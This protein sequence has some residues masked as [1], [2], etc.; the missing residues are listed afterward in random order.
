MKSNYTRPVADILALEADPLSASLNIITS[1]MGDEW[2][3]G[4]LLP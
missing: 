2:D 3:L 4:I 1:G